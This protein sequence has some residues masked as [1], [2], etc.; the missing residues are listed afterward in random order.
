MRIRPARRIR[1]NLRLPGDKSISHRAAILAALARGRSVIE[2]FSSAEDCAATLLC[3]QELGVRVEREGS[4]VQIEGVGLQGLRPTES[5]LDCANSGTTL[6]LLAGALAGQNFNSVLNGDESLRARPMRRVIEPLERMGARISSDTGRAPLRIEGRN[7]LEAISYEMPV[8]S[9][10]V[11][12]AILL[13]GL[14]AQGCT[15]VIARRD[16]TRDHTERLLRW[17][18]VEVES[19]TIEGARAGGDDDALEAI[20]IEGGVE[21]DARGGIVP[22]DISSAAFFIAAA[23]LLPGSQLKITE[24][25]I[26]PTRT[27]LLSVLCSLGADVRVK[28]IRE[29]NDFNEPFGEISVAGGSG[30][31]SFADKQA[32]ALRLLLRA[33]LTAQ[34]ID[35]LP[36]LAIVGTQIPGG[37]EIRDARE[38]RF[39]ESDRISATAQNLRAMGADVEEHADGLTVLRRTRLQGAK[40]NTHQDH[41]I[42]MAFTVASLLAEGES[43][44]VDAECARVSFPEFFEMLESIVER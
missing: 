35:E 4:T 20:A 42:A 16:V 1:G 2:H 43:E 12:S 21:F 7:P 10:Q 3:L 36:L 44:I 19:R 9:A 39:K 30:L 33:P 6:R 18:N 24:V 28:S 29:N 23:A 5:E 34:M 22:G 40:I 11:K 27:R 38:L 8:E 37:L 15:Q 14:N 41:R 32:G 31:S 13:A 17:L 26:N 25:G